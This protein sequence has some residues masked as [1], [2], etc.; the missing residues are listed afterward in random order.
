MQPFDILDLSHYQ[1]LPSLLGFLGSFDFTYRGNFHGKINI[2]AGEFPDWLIQHFSFYERFKLIHS[3][4]RFENL[5]ADHEINNIN[6][7]IELF[8]IARDFLQEGRLPLLVITS[9]C[10]VR[11]LLQLDKGSLQDGAIITSTKLETL[12]RQEID[13]NEFTSPAFFFFPTKG[14]LIFI[15]RL[16]DLLKAYA[17]GNKALYL[18]HSNVTNASSFEGSLLSGKGLSRTAFLRQVDN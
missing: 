15:K 12:D 14:S 7:L 17:S 8:N 13:L 16:I 1:R 10:I 18:K 5:V 3:R 4:A 2:L 6:Y 11:D 9:D